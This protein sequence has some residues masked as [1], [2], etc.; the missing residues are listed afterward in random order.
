MHASGLGFSRSEARNSNPPRS[1]LV[2]LM[3]FDAVRNR[4]Q[5]ALTSVKC[6]R[7]GHDGGENRAGRS[8]I[9]NVWDVVDVMLRG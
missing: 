8:Q 6:E 7:S 3:H 4:P 9:A 1:E 5:R 2:V